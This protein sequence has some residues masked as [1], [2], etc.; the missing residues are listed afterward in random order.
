MRV[1]KIKSSKKGSFKEGRKKRT[2]KKI[3]ESILKSIDSPKTITEISREIESSWL[4]TRRHL[5]WLVL[6][7]KV[8]VEERM[9][10]KF[11]SRF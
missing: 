5:H 10:R 7:E 2:F 1:F 8:K 6:I 11:Y 4:T 9:G 3:R